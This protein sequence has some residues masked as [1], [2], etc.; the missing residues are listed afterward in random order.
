MAITKTKTTGKL[1]TVDFA[2]VETSGTVPEDNYQ[3][4]VF[5][6]NKKS[7]PKAE[8]L[9]FV[10]KISEGKYKGKK[11]WHICTLA[12]DGLFNLKAT[13]TALGVEVPAGK[14]QLS[15]KDY[16][17][18]EMGVSTE[19]EKYKGKMRSRVVDVFSLS[20]VEGGTDDEGEE[21]SGDSSKGGE[22]SPEDD[23]SAEESGVENHSEEWNALAPVE[24]TKKA[25]AAGLEGKWGKK[26][27]DDL[28]DE[29]KETIYPA[30]ESGPNDGAEVEPEAETDS[31]TEEVDL[32]TMNLKQ[33]LAFAKENDVKLT[34]AQKLSSS[35]VRETILK[36]LS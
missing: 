8:Y 22:E 20:E 29:E 11:L 23:N 31:E 7:G 10:L 26:A 33:L 32:S 15:L 14:M 17:G 25:N 19:N 16:V 12:V 24:K 2:G 5:E 3:V 9:E 4:K 6:V 36:A 30:Q 18:L 13:L 1:V 21:E 35:K 28:S 27:W 34:D